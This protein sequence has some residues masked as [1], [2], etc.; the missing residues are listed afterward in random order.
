MFRIGG[1]KMQKQSPKIPYDGTD[2]TIAVTLDTC[3]QAL[4]MIAAAY[5]PSGSDEILSRCISAIDDI[6]SNKTILGFMRENEVPLTCMKEVINEITMK[7]P[8]EVLWETVSE[9]PVTKEGATAG[10]R[11]RIIV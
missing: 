3:K 9:T 6:A 1:T 10:L 2:K 8:K 5:D 11:R 7:R 4:L